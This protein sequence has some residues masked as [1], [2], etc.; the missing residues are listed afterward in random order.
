MGKTRLLSSE[1]RKEVAVASPTYYFYLVFS[2]FTGVYPPKIFP[3]SDLAIIKVGDFP[4]QNYLNKALWK[5]CW[6]ARNSNF[7]ETML[8]FICEKMDPSFFNSVR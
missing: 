3:L 1:N 7:A 6:L 4:A 5:L 8:L 2:H